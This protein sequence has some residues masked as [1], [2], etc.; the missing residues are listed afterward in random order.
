MKRLLVFLSVCLLAAS[1]WADRPEVVIDTTMGKIT[2]AL[3]ADKAP[4]T[5]KNFLKY[6]DAG[7][8]DGT[9]FHRV[10]PGFMIQGGGLD[11]NLK[12]LPEG[13]A[14]HNEADNGL[15]N[16]TGT[17]AMARQNEIDSAIRQFFINVANNPHLDHTSKSCTRKEMKSIAEAAARGLYKP[18][19]CTTFGYAVFGHVVSGMD[20]VHAIEHVKTHAVDGMEDVPVTPVTIT[21]ITRVKPAQPAFP[22][23][24]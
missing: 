21:L 24:K 20:V 4:I 10:I 9:I 17:I 23:G 11:K 15:K 13:D 2:V 3:D 12:A 1:A 8:Y 6:V 14:I 5:V 7:A 16:D 18:K 22:V 19:T